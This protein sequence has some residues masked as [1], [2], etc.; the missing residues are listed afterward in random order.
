VAYESGDEEQKVG[1]QELDRLGLAEGIVLKHYLLRVNS[2]TQDDA[3]G[4]VNLMADLPRPTY[5]MCRLVEGAPYGTRAK[6][7]LDLADSY[8]NLFE[9]KSACD[10]I[11]IWTKHLSRTHFFRSP[12][13]HCLNALPPHNQSC[14][15]GQQAAVVASRPSTLDAW[16]V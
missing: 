16:P 1:F 15:L 12:C 4:V 8:H 14:T 9:M 13:P 3:E 10:L 5:I 6:L 11:L 2:L 7:F